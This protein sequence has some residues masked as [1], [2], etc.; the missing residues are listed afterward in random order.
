MAS[1]EL[2]LFFQ[3]RHIRSYRV[4]EIYESEEPALP[5]LETSGEE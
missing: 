5:K 3:A 4:A 1:E 2:L